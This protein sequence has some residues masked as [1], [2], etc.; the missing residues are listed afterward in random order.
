VEK[1]N[2]IMEAKI[3]YAFGSADS[4]EQLKIRLAFSR[5]GYDGRSQNFNFDDPN[6]I[7]FLLVVG[8]L[9]ITFTSYL[10]EDKEKAYELIKNGT[11][12]TF[13]D[14]KK[15]AFAPKQE[16]YTPKPFD[17]VIGWNNDENESHP[18]IF[19]E[20]IEDSE[21]YRY[22]CARYNY[23]HVKPYKE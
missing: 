19:L 14:V 3:Y 1:N 17:K 5:K 6:N 16:P 20:C 21:P 8:N 4:C 12:L 2:I 23:K 13:E 7:Y 9:N 10:L 22:R 11:F 15:E 18:D